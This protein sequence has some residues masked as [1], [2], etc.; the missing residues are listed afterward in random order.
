M[1]ER[2]PLYSKLLTNQSK[3]I[4]HAVNH[5]DVEDIRVRTIQALPGVS[6]GPNIKNIDDVAFK[7]TGC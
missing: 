2:W 7:G 4:I 3:L 5:M 1:S 6:G